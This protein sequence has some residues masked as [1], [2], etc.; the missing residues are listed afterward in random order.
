MLLDI[1]DLFEDFVPAAKREDTA[2]HL[3]NLVVDELGEEI[4]DDIRGENK[5][6]DRAFHI[7]FDKEEDVEEDDE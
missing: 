6:L 4:I 2:I 1:W 5:Y 3:V 7:L